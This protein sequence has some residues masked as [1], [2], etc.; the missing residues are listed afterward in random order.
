MK[1]RERI[2]IIGGGFAGVTAAR[3]L[4]RT[5]HD[6]VDIQLVDPKSHLEYHGAMYRMVTGRSPMETC[7]PYSDI[8]QK[9]SID[10]V[11]D[12]IESV[13]LQ[14]QVALGASGTHYRYDRVLMALGSVPAYFSLPGMEKNSFSMQG[15]SGS[16]RLKN[17]L[18]E[19]FQS[20]DK[21]ECS[22]RDRAF[23]I[24]VVGGGP[25]GVELAGELAWYVK[26]RLGERTYAQ[27]QASV[28]LLEAGP[29]ILGSMSEQFS[30][31]VTKR[32]QTLG[33]RVKCSTAVKQLEGNV[34][35]LSSG[36][37]TGKTIIW[38]A[39]V[40]AHPLL[41]R[42]GLSTH[43]NGRAIVDDELRAKGWNNVYVLGD[44]AET[45]KSGMAQTALCH[46][47]FV[48]KLIHSEL[49][50]LEHDKLCEPQII[51]AIPVGP[52]WAACNILG[53]N[54]YGKI[55]WCLRRAV[56]ASVFLSLLPVRKAVQAFLSMN[57]K[58]SCCAV[59]HR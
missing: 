16:C 44:N 46:G 17:H 41:E 7:I 56:D 55:G 12:C 22:E 4:W 50:G 31:R 37:L 43:A 58:E 45:G 27:L 40:R 57:E 2:L 47:R 38:T 49:T 18:E 13:D 51:Y 59:V 33:V 34:L 52:K 15:T 11:R 9:N 32:L 1:Q 21:I 5:S 20:H 29:R 54:V 36:T 24:I 35:Q 26:K 25:T 39:G 8:F 10:T 3:E 23:S 19:L 14:K 48:A 6:R 30:Q 53:M 28:H 42:S